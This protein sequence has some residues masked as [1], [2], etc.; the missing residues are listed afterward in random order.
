MKKDI[1]VI[2]AVVILVLVGAGTALGYWQQGKAANPAPVV[3]ATTTQQTSPVVSTPTKPVSTTPPAGPF[4]HAYGTVTLSLGQS[5]KFPDVTITPI[6]ITQDSRCPV[7]V[8]CI[9]AG[10][11][12][13][14]V[15]ISSPSST[16]T[17]TITLGKA[18]TLPAGTITLTSVTPSK[19]SKTSISDASYR[20]TFD[21]EKRTSATCY[22]GGCSAEICSDNPGAVS[23]CIYRAE[24]A[25]YRSA[26]CERQASGA[27]GWTQTPELNS[28]LASTSGGP[29]TL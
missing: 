10:T 18:Y 17:Q 12:S 15:R 11:V 27:C 9:Q 19:N 13:V 24:Y 29:Y 8:Q 6:S 7:D 20:L 23:S 2:T 25:C 14:S 5:A 1:I 21:V 3:T 16:D 26:T 22:V 4:V 28:C